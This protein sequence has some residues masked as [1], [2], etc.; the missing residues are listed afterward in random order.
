MY[1]FLDRMDLLSTI[2]FS[3]FDFAKL[4]VPL[5]IIMFVIYKLFSPL[6]D[7]LDDRF[8]LSWLKSVLALNLITTFVV[9]FGIYLYFFFLGGVL[10]TPM[11]FGYDIFEQLLMILVALVRIIIVTIIL[12]FLLLFFEF[13][14][15]FVVESLGKKE[16][17]IN[18]KEFIGIFVSS[19]IFLIL[20]LF[21]FSWVPLGIFVYIF[22]GFLEEM[23]LLISLVGI[24]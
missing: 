6:R 2:L 17:S 21:F 23:P 7:K 12:S 14:S 13:V 3:I 22:Y 5:S 15:S 1:L 16:Y 10:A 9:L 8:E 24:I 11:E 20:L 19:I 18:T 4:L